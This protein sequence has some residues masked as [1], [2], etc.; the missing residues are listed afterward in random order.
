VKPQAEDLSDLLQPIRQFKVELVH[1]L[2]HLKPTQS[3]SRNLLLL[4]NT[5]QKV[6]PEMEVRKLICSFFAMWG[7]KQKE[8]PSYECHQG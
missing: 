5:I 3:H 1:T 4:N 7:V 6:I 8:V 2:T